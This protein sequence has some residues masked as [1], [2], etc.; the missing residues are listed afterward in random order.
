[1]ATFK[2]ILDESDL[3]A[4]LAG[5]AVPS[6][7]VYPYSIEIVL[8]EDIHKS[9]SLAPRDDGDKADDIMTLE[10]C[11]VEE[12]NRCTELLFEYRHSGQTDMDNRIGAVLL[13]ATIAI[14]ECD[15]VA[16]NEVHQ[17]LKGLE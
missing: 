14:N 6:G 11:V 8:E 7:R 9:Y 15:Y 4:L 2:C 1:M 10:S 16:L 12:I 13:A 3:N 5:E 17:T